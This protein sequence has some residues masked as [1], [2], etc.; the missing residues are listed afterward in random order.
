MAILNALLNQF[1][2]VPIEAMDLVNKYAE[3]D[4]FSQGNLSGNPLPAGI[5]S[6]NMGKNDLWISATAAITQSALLTTDNDFD[7]LE[8]V[9]FD[10]IKIPL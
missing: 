5:T 8:K 2:I 9:Y 7:H 1:L 6:R 10:L 3:I 4:A